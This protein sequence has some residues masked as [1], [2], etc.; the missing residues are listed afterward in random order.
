MVIGVVARTESLRADTAPLEEPP[1]QIRGRTGVGREREWH[2]ALADGTIPPAADEADWRRSLELLGSVR[3]NDKI[4]SIRCYPAGLPQGACI[5]LP[6]SAP[7]PARSRF[8]GL[9]QHEQFRH[10]HRTETALRLCGEGEVH[11]LELA[12][13]R[14]A[15]AELWGYYDRRDKQLKF[16]FRSRIQ[17]EIGFPGGVDLEE[18]LGR[19]VV[20]PL[21]VAWHAPVA[22]L[23]EQSDPES[24]RSPEDEDGPAL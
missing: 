6:E 8:Y 23:R 21:R 1:H 15:A 9:R 12:P 3:C 11:A 10:V 2:A 4:P 20:V 7:V 24:G 19:G 18:A 14:E 16:I 13:T 5:G 22:E 17:V